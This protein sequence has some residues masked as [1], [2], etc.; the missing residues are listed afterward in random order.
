MN[1]M[2]SSTS[3]TASTLARLGRDVEPLKRRV[4]EGSLFGV[5]EIPSDLIESD[6]TKATYIT[7]RKGSNRESS[8]TFTIEEAVKAGLTGKDNWR[9]YPAA[10]LRARAAMG[11]SRAI[12]QDVTM[13]L[14][15]PDEAEE[16]REQ[17]QA[18]V[19]TGRAT[20]RTLD[21]LTRKLDPMEVQPGP[22]QPATHEVVD[23]VTGEVTEV[24][25]APTTSGQSPDPDFVEPPDKDPAPETQASAEM[26]AA[27]NV[28]APATRSTTPPAN[29][30]GLF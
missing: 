11:L 2:M 15:D 8:L 3:S 18:M 22:A 21:D 28:Q 17:A 14:V 5:A 24:P 12:Y 23:Q 25:D 20:P 4:R 6:A 19:E 26:K 10:M 30:G 16:I 29:A 27:I 13:G 7:K 1:K 9:K